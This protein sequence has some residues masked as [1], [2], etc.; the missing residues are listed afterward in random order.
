MFYGKYMQDVPSTYPGIGDT[1]FIL[2]EDG[3]LS[4]PVVMGSMLCD[5]NAVKYRK[6]GYSGR[7]NELNL[8]SRIEGRTIT[9]NDSNM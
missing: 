8:A 6:V 4:K 7:K 3:N 2:F 1:V 9:D 5:G